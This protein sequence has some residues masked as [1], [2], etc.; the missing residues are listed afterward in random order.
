M[1]EKKGNSDNAKMFKKFY[2]DIDM[3]KIFYIDRSY[4]NLFLFLYINYFNLTYY[5]N[6]IWCVGNR[7]SNL[8][9]RDMFIWMVI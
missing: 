3:Y 1:V 2:L 7:N 8:W 4:Y 9:M 5:S 6:Q